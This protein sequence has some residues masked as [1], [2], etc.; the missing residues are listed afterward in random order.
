MVVYFYCSYNMSAVGYQRVSLNPNTNVQEVCS[1]DLPTV[2]M[3]LTHSGAE[4]AFGLDGNKYYFV[5]KNMRVV[6]ET[7]PPNTPGRSWYMN[8]ALVD[9]DKEYICAMAYEAYTNYQSFVN[10]LAGC[11]TAR[12][13]NPSY[14]ISGERWKLLIK[15]ASTNYRTFIESGTVD[16]FNAPS[17]LSQ[18][19]MQEAFALLRTQ[20][21]S[22]KYE[23]AV[24]ES[25]EE[26]FRSSY[27]CDNN[28][29]LRHFVKAH[30]TSSTT[31]EKRTRQPIQST[32]ERERDLIGPGLLLGTFALSVF[33][34]YQI[35]KAVGAM[36]RRKTRRQ[37]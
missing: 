21:I 26:Y 4:T 24:L 30:G 14:A 12:D 17:G 8:L 28:S 7:V 20:E 31:T 5:I 15:E 35:G 37:R 9:S 27:R 29:Q 25:N 34:M 10:K 1:I 32:R 2:D 36:R 3:L 18:D 19:Q 33:G 16:F 6:K 11:L 13:E 23:F 22:A